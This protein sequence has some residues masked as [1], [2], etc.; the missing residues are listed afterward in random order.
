MHLSFLP[1]PK[2]K[3]ETYRAQSL[4][5]HITLRRTFL[6]HAAQGPGQAC[7]RVS[8]GGPRKKL[9]SSLVERALAKKHRVGLIQRH[10]SPVE[11][12]VFVDAMSQSAIC[13]CVW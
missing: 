1:F 11:I 5:R 12:Q 8:G 7:P 10:S 3:K 9:L 13:I 4:L 6:S 2:W